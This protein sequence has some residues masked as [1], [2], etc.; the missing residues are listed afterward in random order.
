M[1]AAHVTPK[2]NSPPSGLPTTILELPIDRQKTAS[3]FLKTLN[4][5]VPTAVKNGIYTLDPED[6]IKAKAERLAV[7][8]EDA[9]KRNQQSGTYGTQCRTVAANLKTN[10]ELCNGLLTKTLSPDALATM[11]S[12][13]MAS[14]E[15]KQKAAVMKAKADKASIMITEDDGPRIRR[16]HKGDEVI[17]GDNGNVMDGIPIS[18]RQRRRSMMDPNG[19]MASR[20]RENS[21]GND[22][23]LPANINDYRSQDDIRAHVPPTAPL[24]IDTKA[25]LK[26]KGSKKDFNFNQILSHVPQ[27]SPTGPSHNRRPSGV[28]QPSAGPEEDPEIDRLLQD[29]G[30]ESPPYSPAEHDADPEIIWKG[31]VNMDSI[32]KFPAFAKLVGGADLTRTANPIPWSDIL[33]KDLRVAGRIDQDKANEYLCSLR[34]SPPTDVVVVNLTPTGES[35]E[36]GFKDMYDYFHDKH[37]YGVLTNKGVGNI[38][39][40]YLVPVPPSPANFPDFIV[41]LEGHKVPEVRKGPMILVALVIRTQY[42]D[43]SYQ[44]YDSPANARSPSMPNHPVPARQLSISGAGPA[45]S[46]IA[47][48]NGSF[49][50]P[51]ASSQSPHPQP[52]LS[53][54]DLQRRQDQ[55][56]AQR[57][58]EETARTILG[59]YA[60]APTVGFLM[61][62]AFQMRALE[63]EVIRGILETDDKARIDLQHLSQVLEV[64]MA[65]QSQLPQTQGTPQAPPQAHSQASPPVGAGPPV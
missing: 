62:Q 29:D 9:I 52:Q 23:E 16:T 17:E 59:T 44:Q 50:P 63:W 2:Q 46:P 27:Q 55:E 14:K 60:Q 37:R 22:V 35:S 47:P 57:Q 1:S 33:Q 36:S 39:D 40:T 19:D 56:R 7:Q 58:G 49:Q 18:S 65:Q 8:I 15:Q 13:D 34:Y 21:P 38:R 31:M 4:I 6:S 3:L 30:I 53:P 64:R 43:F 51:S 28:I 45:M 24:S 20:S 48:Q 25:T 12:D 5:T 41:N 54:E 10:Q 61:P 26:K 32:A 42:D 11:T